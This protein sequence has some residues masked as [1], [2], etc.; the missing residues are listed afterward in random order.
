M[1]I[2]YWFKIPLELYV[3]VLV[4]VSSFRQIWESK[5]ASLLVDWDIVQQSD[6]FHPTSDLEWPYVWLCYEA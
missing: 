6:P 5:K 4:E 1:D 2:I 3:E